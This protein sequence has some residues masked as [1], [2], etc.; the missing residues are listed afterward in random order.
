MSQAVVNK[1]FSHFLM[2][3]KAALAGGK[4][5]MG[6]ALFELL[7]SEMLEIGIHT[8][9]YHVLDGSWQQQNPFL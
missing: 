8:S 3:G 5:S 2:P 1:I 4:E 7:V 9:G 6:Y